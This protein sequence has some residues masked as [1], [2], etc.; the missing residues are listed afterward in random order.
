LIKRVLSKQASEYNRLLA[1][2]DE[3]IEQLTERVK[4]LSHVK[5]Y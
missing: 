3:R 5:I 2:K 1:K 4:Q